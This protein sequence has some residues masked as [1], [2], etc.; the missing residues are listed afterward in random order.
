VF[1]F[2]Y[3]HVATLFVAECT[4][5][6]RH[7]NAAL[8][9]LPQENTPA[10]QGHINNNNKGKA[11]PVLKRIGGVRLQ[12]NALCTARIMPLQKIEMNGEF[13]SPA[14]LLLT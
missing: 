14:V 4:A 11:F 1:G 7:C 2:S 10:Q 13:R 3:Y 8:I 12:F 6:S 5:I 9:L